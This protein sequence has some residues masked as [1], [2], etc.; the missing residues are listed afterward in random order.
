MDSIPAQRFCR[1]APKREAGNEFSLVVVEEMAGRIMR[2]LITGGAGFIGSHLVEA[3]LS[4]G[5]EVHV[6][7]DLSTGRL[8]NL[9]AV[10][11]DPRFSITIGKLEVG[12]DLQEEVER[13]DI[14]HHLAA[15]VGVRRVL[16]RPLETLQ[17]NLYCTECVFEAASRLGTRVLV[18]STSEVYGKSAQVPFEEDGDLTLGATSKSRWSYAASKIIDEFLALSYHSEWR[19]PVTVVRL[20]NTVGPRQVSDY[21]MVLPT[22]VS[23]ALAGEPLT[24]HGSGE[25]TR[26]FS[27]I[28]DVVRCWCAL[29]DS[30][31]SVGEVF[32]VG[33][34]DEI[35]ILELAKL[36]KEVTG[37]DSPI[38]KTSYHLA[39]PSGYEDMPRRVPSVAKLESEIGFRPL[40]SPRK[41]VQAVADHFSQ[42]QLVRQ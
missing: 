34:D 10:R 20:F 19:L 28:D 29:A 21:G 14:V 7:D 16:Q 32:N 12:N 25:Q 39:Y 33:S 1:I 9:E 13:A 11:S 27:A 18:A 4:R 24:I 3:L 41:I 5:D 23:Q 8:E 22:F 42:Q 26:C 15:V 30:R 2:H 6:I 36:V 31:R 35:S 40:T 38:T 37:S 17:T